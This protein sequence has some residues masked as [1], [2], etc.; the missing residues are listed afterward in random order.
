MNDLLQA[1]VNDIKV[2]AGYRWDVAEVVG[3]HFAK[4]HYG[5]YGAILVLS[6]KIG[7]D[8]MFVGS[9][10]YSLSDP[11]LIKAIQ[12]LTDDRIATNTWRG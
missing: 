8:N 11:E 12:V 3:H 2:P 7:S 5:T 6:N 1:I 9:R 10:D 4:L